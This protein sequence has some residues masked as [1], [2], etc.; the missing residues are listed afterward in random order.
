LK[1]KVNKFEFML[2]S[3]LGKHTSREFRRNA[4][5][6]LKAW[7]KQS[8]QGQ[9][10]VMVALLLVALIGMLALILDGGHSY[11]QRRAAQTA[12]DAGALAG[13][14]VLCDT[15]DANL[16]VD[17]ALEYAIDRNGASQA[18][19]TVENDVV[20][21]ETYITF[22]TFFGRIFSRPQITSAAIAAAKCSP[23]GS[24][25]GMLPIAFPCY[26]PDPG[27]PSQS[28]DCKVIYGDDTQSDQWHI[29]N[30]MMTIVMDTGSDSD[31]CAPE[32]PIDCDINNDGINDA[33]TGNAARGWLDLDGGGGGSVSDWI[34]GGYDGDA[35]NHHT[36][37]GTEG[38][39]MSS[40]IIDVEDYQ[41]G[42]EVMV[43]IFDRFCPEGPPSVECPTLY[44]PGDN[45]ILVGGGGHTYY[46][47]VGFALFHITCVKSPGG[48]HCPYRDYLV[49]EG[50]TFFD[51]LKDSSI[52]TIEGYFVQG[53]HPGAIGGGGV[54]HGLYVI[55][56]TR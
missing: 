14:A 30:G 21:V 7:I 19:A 54:D 49:D 45:E 10:L 29:D 35:I 42:N 6:N 11:M 4:M 2:K 20:T 25:Y 44:D 48:K 16:A 36:W 55:H 17:S 38:G 46:R 34:M 1:D 15:G 40:A 47:V 22:S 37:F 56:L 51:K 52:K 27:D 39:D 24:A 53:T 23:A 8:S 33:I 31:A 28:F 13:A 18:Y 32:G 50:S 9:S 26:P 3:D 12:A 5:K 43:P 41:E